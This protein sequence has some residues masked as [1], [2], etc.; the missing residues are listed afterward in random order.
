MQ[1]YSFAKFLE[2]HFYPA[3]VKIVQGAGCE[4]NIYQHHVRFFACKGM[5]VRFQADPITLYEVVYPPMRIRV[6]PETQLR[7]KNTDFQ[8]LHRQNID[9]YSG[10]ISDL[11]LINIDA[12]TGDEESDARLTVEINALISRA[13]VEREELARMINTVYKDSAPNDTLAL[14]KVRAFRQDRIVSWQQDFDRLPKIRGPPV[15][16]EKKSRKVSAFTS[17]LIFPKSGASEPPN[18]GPTGT[19]ETEETSSRL[20]RKVNVDSLASSASE[21]SEPEIA[22]EPCQAGNKRVATDGSGLPSLTGEP[23]LVSADTAD[24]ESDSTVGAAKDESLSSSL[25]PASPT[26]VR[27]A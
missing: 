26:S 7:I 2:L 4:H 19:L 6:R 12:A 9:W 18:V 10:L 1:R 8:R 17:V 20:K 13:E 25:V 24:A 14:N 23:N 22:A 16:L 27:T 5:T 11:K 3:D 21:A 15:A